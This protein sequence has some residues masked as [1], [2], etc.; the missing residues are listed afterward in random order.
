MS[1]PTMQAI[2]VHEFGGPEQLRLERIPCPEPQAGEVLVRIHAVGILPAEWKMRRGFFH[3]AATPARFPYIPGSAFAGVIESVGPDVTTF[4]PG[5]AVFGRTTHG[6]Y[7]E[8]TT[9]A[10]ETIALKHDSLSFAE[11]ATI[12]GGATVAYTALFENI[13]L[14]PDDRILIHGGAG[15]VGL[16]AVQFAVRR[17]AHV[18]ATSSA[19]NVD[20]VRSLGA[21][22]VVDYTSTAFEPAS[23]GV[24]AVLDTVGGETLLRSLRVV[25]PG[26][27]VVSLLQEPPREIAR[28]LGLRVMKNTAA[29]PFPSTRLLNSIAEMMTSGRVKTV[30]QT[31]FPL[32]QARQAHVLSQTGHGRGR[33]VL[34]MVDE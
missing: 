9:V 4:Q 12:S 5:Q 1:Q 2:Q 30:I 3:Q 8:Y 29:L 34:S 31:T 26:G 15:G 33:I 18:V 25:R 27:I 19:A 21:E 6:A 7:A 22:V 24:D 16:F 13:A 28:E 23:R 32:A 20:F 10:T 17:G 11:V 14:K